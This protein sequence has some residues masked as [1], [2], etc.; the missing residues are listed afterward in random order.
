MDE[1]VATARGS[2]RRHERSDL[3]VVGHI[4]AH[5]RRAELLGRGRERLLAACRE[6]ELPAAPAGKLRATASPMPLEPPVMTAVRT[7]RS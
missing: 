7:A 4:A 6:H 5:G 2:S 1:Q 3:A